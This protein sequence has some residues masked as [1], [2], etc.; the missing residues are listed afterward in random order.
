[1]IIDIKEWM[2]QGYFNKIEEN[3]PECGREKH[4]F[5]LL[6]LILGQSSY[7]KLYIIIIYNI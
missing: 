2:G 7:H 4:W 6:A 3:V 5:L 1:V